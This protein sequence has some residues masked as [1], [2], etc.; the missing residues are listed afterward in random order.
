MPDTMQT[1]EKA[2]VFAP[3][4]AFFDRLFGEKQTLRQLIVFWLMGGIAG[5]ID[6]AVFAVCN[7]FVFTDLRDIDAQ[8]W[9]FDYGVANGGLCALL[10]FAVSF[11]V[12]QTVNFFVQRKATFSATNNVAVSAAL[13]AV[14]VLAVYVLILWLP[15]VIGAPVYALL[16]AG[17][18]AIAIKLL[19]QFV[20][21]L[22]Q[23]PINKWVIM[24]VGG[25]KKA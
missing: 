1:K 13:Y 10:A 17:A 14:T 21:F 7:Y 4:K 6:L 5:V 23:F 19:M 20:S 8:F 12:S 3:V 15:T 24:R 9:L 22:I 2:G 25:R 11:A 18:G 16:G